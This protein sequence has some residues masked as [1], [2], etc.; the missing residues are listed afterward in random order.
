MR[1]TKRRR[2]SSSQ[3]DMTPMIDIVFLLIIFF[4]TVSQ[5]SEVNNE[6]LDLPKQSGAEDQKPAVLTI[7]VVQDGT[8]V[9]AGNPRSL[10]QFISLVSDE[11]QKVGDDPSRLTCVIRADQNGVSKTVNEVANALQRLQIQRVRF[12]V[13]VPQ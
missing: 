12:A 1:L 2:E 6:R 11:L 5:I 4:M 8:I 13:E 9:I 10:P 3:I 7:N